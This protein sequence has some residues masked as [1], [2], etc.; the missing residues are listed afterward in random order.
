[1]N[2]EVT[3]VSKKKESIAVAPAAVTVINGNPNIKSEELT[4][5]ELG[6]RGEPRKD[7]SIDLSVFYNNYN[8]L[9]SVE[10][11]APIPGSPIVLPSSFGNL[12]AGDTYGGEISATFRVTED[13][14]I[15]G[16]YSLLESTFWYTAPQGATPPGGPVSTSSDK[17]SAPRNQAQIHSYLDITRNLQFNAS[18]F[19]V[20][21]VN[22][23]SI[24]GYI[25][26]DLNV[27]WKP[28][29]GMSRSVGVANLF[30][31]HHPEFGS[32]GNQGA[33][34]ETPRTV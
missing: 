27:V 29:E 11:E 9:Q 15:A 26:T 20:G 4:A 8:R 34:S 19:Y 17:G 23:F 6:Y 33:A 22:R 32:T 16:S 2:V 28:W 13:W 12:I 14:R 24:P 5:Y 10:S 1:M 30:D 31:N 21:D 18:L 25:S 3:T 7:V